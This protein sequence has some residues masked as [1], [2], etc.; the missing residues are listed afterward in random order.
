MSA[1]LE[2][3]TEPLAHLPPS[4]VGSC[5]TGLGSAETEAG[6]LAGDAGQ[7]PVASAEWVVI[8][9]AMCAE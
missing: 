5:D 4:A 8:D 9:P 7:R 6:R 1:L 3:F 2:R